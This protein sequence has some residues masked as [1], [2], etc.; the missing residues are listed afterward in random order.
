MSVLLLA[1]ASAFLAA[2]LLPVSSEVVLAGLAA[3][4][5]VHLL[6]LWL[7]AS[8]GNTGGAVLNYGLG[9]L[10]LRL[11]DRRWFPATEAQLARGHAWFE[12]WGAWTLL[13]AWVPV[14]GDALTV[15]AG[16]LRVRPILFVVLV[17]AGKAARYA[18]LLWAIS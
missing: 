5:G 2:T 13:L 15:V 16:V 6:P 14:V 3:R 9:R 8:L 18:A 17:F 4:P 11:A 1:F 7:A 10:A 12:R